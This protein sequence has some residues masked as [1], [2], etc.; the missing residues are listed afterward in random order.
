MRR[1]IGLNRT[2]GRCNLLVI[3]QI[4]H[5]SHLF[6]LRMG[7]ARSSDLEARLGAAQRRNDTAIATPPSTPQRWSY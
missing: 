4:H 1:K 3:E 7:G 2:Q 5:P 6:V